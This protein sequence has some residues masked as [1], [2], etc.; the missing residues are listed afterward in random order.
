MD[1]QNEFVEYCQ[2]VGIS[3]QQ[4]PSAADL[5]RALARAKEKYSSDVFDMIQSRCTRPMQRD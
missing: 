2:A 1:A 5:G 4:K 3:M